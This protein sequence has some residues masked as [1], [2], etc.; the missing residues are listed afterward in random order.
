MD[1]LTILQLNIDRYFALLR[2]K[3]D[4]ETRRT[5]ETLLQEAQAAK[6][7]LLSMKGLDNQQ[8]EKIRFR[9]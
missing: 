5:V 9:P 8:A 4:P 3:I 6:A 2:R 1:E 7:S